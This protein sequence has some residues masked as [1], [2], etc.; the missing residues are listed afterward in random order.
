MTN[1]PTTLALCISLIGAGVSPLVHAR[2][3]LRAVRPPALALGM[4]E[5]PATALDETRLS[6]ELIW[7]PEDV[8]SYPAKPVRVRS[9]TV[10]VDEEEALDEV[11]AWHAQHIASRHE[12]VQAEALHSANGDA[13][14]AQSNVNAFHPE[15]GAESLL[16]KPSTVSL[17]NTMPVVE[18]GHVEPVANEI[19]R[20]GKLRWLR[21]PKQAVGLQQPVA[22]VELRAGLE[23]MQ[24]PGLAT[25]RDAGQCKD[26]T[27]L[28]LLAASGPSRTGLAPSDRFSSG[29]STQPDKAPGSASIDRLM[30]SL[31][32]GL[33]EDATTFSRVH[34]IAAIAER[35]PAAGIDPHASKP[36]AA[37]AKPDHRA[38]TYPV[39]HRKLA[40]E[41]QSSI[42]LRN[43]EAILYPEHGQHEAVEQETVK[44]TVT[45]QTER[46]LATLLE[47]SSAREAPAQAAAFGTREAAITSLKAEV[48]ARTNA[49]AGSAPLAATKHPAIRVDIDLTVPFLAQPVAAVAQDEAMHVDIDLTFPFISE[50]VAAVASSHGKNDSDITAEPPSATRVSIA[51]RVQRPNPF[52]A[53]EIAVS[54]ALLDTVRG[55]FV[56]EG[57]SVSFGIE[58]AVYINGSLITTT[59]LNVSGLGR[60][61]AGNGTMAFDSNSIALLQ[62]G[63]GNTVSAGSL[64]PTSIGAVI[65][66]TLDGQKIQNLT[67]IN[68][69]VNSLG[70]LK[71]LNLQSSLRSAVIDSLRR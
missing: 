38:S 66:N 52:G 49:A 1:Q 14:A 57:L 21:K 59:H 5:M 50:P 53:E 9:A 47:V 13:R 4:L 25:N 6:A 23:I 19:G 8:A 54:E 58:R 33:L 51:K 64:S 35:F 42:V 71:G 12:R 55:G 27:S 29:P 68:A 28:H 63:A 37:S 39:V 31:G 41:S 34:L 18:Q 43:L 70:V 40:A 32:A 30:E 46:V 17:I 16:E 67:V 62:S 69:T 26:E 44:L 24:V 3:D 45:S 2:A 56:T 11:S 10:A 22:T 61:S 7:R 36:Q 48:G 60:V 15:S 20:Q 65:Q